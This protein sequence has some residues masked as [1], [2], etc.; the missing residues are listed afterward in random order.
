MMLD[1]VRSLLGPVPP[2]YE[3]AE[4]LAALALAAIFVRAVLS[5]LDMARSLGR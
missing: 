5:V 1:L 2:G 3:F 4:Y